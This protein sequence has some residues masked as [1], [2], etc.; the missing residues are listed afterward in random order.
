MAL[1]GFVK[2]CHVASADRNKIKSMQ[3]S[4]L[5]KFSKAKEID[6]SVYLIPI[7]FLS[8]L[9]LGLS[10]VSAYGISYD[11]PV[12]R[13]NGGISLKYSLDKLNIGVFKN[14]SVLHDIV[15]PLKEYRDR[16][17]GVVFDLPA[18]AIERI[19]KVD[20]PREQFLLR[21]TLTF[22]LFWL[23][24]IFLYFLLKNSLRSNAYAL[25]GTIIFL[26]SPRIFA[27]AFY[28]SKDITLM[29]LGTA[30]SFT[31]YLLINRPSY[32]IAS[33]HGV[34][35]ALVIDT[36]IVG[37]VFAV[38]SILVYLYYIWQTRQALRSYQILLVYIITTIIS[39]YIFWPWL[40]ESPL[41]NIRIAFF[42]MA[43]FRWPQYNFY[44]GDFVSAKQLPWHYA[45]TWI[46]FTTPPVYLLASFVGIVF[47]LKQFAY[48]HLY[49]MPANDLYV[50][51]FACAIIFGT[52][53]PIVTLNSTLYDGWR[54]LYFIYPSVIVLAASA[55]KALDAFFLKSKLYFCRY[56]TYSLLG[57]QMLAVGFWMF[58][59][60]PFQN[61][62]FNSLAPKK[63]VD[64]FE[65]DY[66][67]LTNLSMLKFIHDSDARD[68]IY[69]SSL[70]SSSIAQSLLMLPADYRRKRIIYVG[71]ID[72]ADYV[73]SNFRFLNLSE[74]RHLDSNWSL[75]HEMH[76]DGNRVGAI[77]KR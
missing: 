75:F 65:G 26:L 34:L 74:P 73:I 57:L 58:S 71:S 28:N 43:N 60:H 23:S 62:Y 70:G 66:W 41:N 25:I 37:L 69:V 72:Q 24:S 51:L 36:R 5:D 59:V 31:I 64:W 21:H 44:W 54:Q 6:L 19:L 29:A 8:I 49:R 18:F 77:Y 76:I 40:W 63:W 47:T 42:N 17:Y 46:A 56:L 61:L 53:I 38:A 45:L 10:Q 2:S 32:S 27:D 7:F 68:V 14:D 33:L 13:D 16:D 55:L 3:N 30:C 52:L 22:L 4:L 48:K 35:T 50:Q 1:F 67:G 39:V 20:N 15:T 11:E 12:S 9:L